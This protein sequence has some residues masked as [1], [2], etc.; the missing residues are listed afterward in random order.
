MVY[1]KDYLTI[2]NIVVAILAIIG[3]VWLITSIWRNWK[4]GRINNWP[5]VNAV[6]VNSVVE[7]EKVSSNFGS[8]YLD[9]RY[10]LGTTD[11]STKFIPRILYRYNING[12]E[13]QSN[14]VIYGPDKAYNSLDIKT[15]MGNIGPGSTIQ[16]Y[17]NPDNPG[18]TYVLNG[19]PNYMGALL[20]LILL[21][22]AGAIAY[23][24]NYMQKKKLY[25]NPRMDIYSPTLTTEEVPRNRRQTTTVTTQR[26]VDRDITNRR[27]FH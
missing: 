10:L 12:R 21:A 27:A 19:T 15:L 9:P 11:S 20:G 13:Y 18:E 16:V 7:P 22:L 3:L 4:I 1:W 25:S 2:Q 17:Y 6:V 5:K 8:T 24:H 26:T 14:N 23:H